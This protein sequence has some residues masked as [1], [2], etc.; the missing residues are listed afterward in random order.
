MLSVAAPAE[1][2]EIEPRRWTHTPNGANFFG[3]GYGHS[4]GNVFFDQSL[5]IEDAN[6]EVHGFGMGFIHSFGLFGK[7]SRFEMKVPYGYGRWQGLLE[8]EPASTSRS[9]FADPEIRF[10]MNLYGAPSMDPREF[11]QFRATQ[12]SSTIVGAALKV[13]LP[14]GEYDR[15]R[16]INLGSNRWVFKPQLGVV[17]QRGKWTGE[18]TGSVWLF[19]END[20][21]QGSNTLKQDPF[22]T[23][24]GHLIYT[25]RPGLWASLSGG[26]G[27][28]GSPEVN[29]VDTGNRQGNFLWAASFGFA[30]NRYHGVKIAFLNGRTVEDTGVD[31]NQVQVG[32]S[33][34]W[35]EG[36]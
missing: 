3:F 29:G 7:S 6:S 13:T 2:Q 36:L 11:A 28:G 8:G 22:Y 25:A 4:D 26:Y 14:M 30:F 10:A 15:N 32:Y 19:G 5:Q 18:I 17:H 35:G 21:Y 9:G 1:A 33:F 31:Y 27:T 24:Q 20:R 12:K 16:L 23:I 34:M